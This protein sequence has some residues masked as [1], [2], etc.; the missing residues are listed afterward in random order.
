MEYKIHIGTLLEIKKGFLQGTFKVMY[1]GMSNEDTFVLTPYV[2]AGY[3]GFSP[4]IYYNIDSPSIQ[5]LDT[6]FDVLEVTSE[7]IIL[8]ESI[9]NTKT[10]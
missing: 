4:N 7:Y 10:A 2:P 6:K 9:L 8:A 1:C 5:I 3:Q